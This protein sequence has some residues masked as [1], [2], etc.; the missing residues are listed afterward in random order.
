HPFEGMQSGVI[1]FVC[2]LAYHLLAVHVD[3]PAPFTDDCVLDHGTNLYDPKKAEQVRWYDIDLDAP[4][5]GRFVQIAKDYTDSMNALIQVVKDLIVPVYPNAVEFIDD[6]FGEMHKMLDQPY[7]DEI[8]GIAD[9]SGIPLGQIVMYNLIYEIIAGCTSVVAADENGSLFHARNL[10]FGLWI[11]WN[12]IGH[13]W[14]LSRALSNN[15]VNIRW[16]RGGKVLYKSNNF[17]GFVGVYNG[18]KQGKFALTANAR[19][20]S[21][22]PVMHWFAG[23]TPNAKWMT[24]LARE[25]ME[26]DNTYAEAKEHLMSTELLS[27]VYYILSGTKPDEACVISR[28][29]EKTEY[30]TEITSRKDPW[31]LLQTNY[32]QDGW[33]WWIDDRQMPGENCMRKLGK[34]NVGFQGMYNVLSSRTSLNKLTAYTVLMRTDTADLET[35]LQNCSGDCWG[36]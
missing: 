25:T 29:H 18:V 23:E 21:D 4:A 27:N 24:W 15:I 30:L 33:V 17:A 8:Q 31:F 6:I 7:R 12:P 32:E 35:Y 14:E 9:A 26:N 5:S 34:K 10:D 22:H 20:G 19:G 16:L 11:G 28:G 13:E 2:L 36:W 3:I 1:V